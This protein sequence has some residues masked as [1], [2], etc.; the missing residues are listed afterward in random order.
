MQ[1]QVTEAFLQTEAGKLAESILR[2]CVHC[3][4]CTATCPT[5]QVTGDELDSPRGRIYQ[6]KQVFEGM[7]ATAS[8]QHHLDRCLTCRNCETTCPSGV[9][10]GRLLDLG[11]AEVERQV[12]RKPLPAIKRFLLRK[13]VTNRRVFEPS[14]RLA[15]SL[16]TVLPQAIQGKVLPAQTGQTV[17][18]KPA[19]RKMLVLAGCVQPA[20]LPDI[21]QAT[22]KLLN[23]V[24]IEAVVA[25]KAGC[26][27]AVNLHLNA[28]EAARADMRRN[29]DA[30][31][32]H[33]Q[34][35]VEAILINASGCGVLVKDYAYELRED[36][37][38][39]AKA[40]TI[41]SMAKD[42]VEVFA[43]E[44]DNLKKQLQAIPPQAVAYHPPCTLQ[45]GQKL[46]GSVETLLNHLGIHLMLP[47]EANLCCGS[48]GTYA[49][50]EPALSQA[51]KARKQ[52]HLADLAP[53]VILSANV[54][55]IAHLS[56]GA[57]VPVRHWLS[58]VADWV[59]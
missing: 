13:L 56:D 25:E 10:Y 43:A 22:V 48:A 24:G 6:I 19:S 17:A 4:F 53:E 20:M 9:E 31:W 45:H 30:W 8:I 32:P 16:R 39:A 36:A 44:A 15:Q 3:G 14:Y 37:N 29:I 1:T 46:A 54:G 42:A 2:R 55:C 38:Y 57:R 41:A 23:A 47:A 5:F 7:S 33:V 26:C 52:Q 58:Y 11:R 35:G 27:G 50:F 49:F 40:E 28:H 34:N 21:H 59:K 18:A 12:G 51:V